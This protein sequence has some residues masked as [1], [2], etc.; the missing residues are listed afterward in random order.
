MQ[1]AS[2]SLD[3]AFDATARASDRREAAQLCESLHSHAAELSAAVSDVAALVAA[4]EEGTMPILSELRR[5]PP[6]SKAVARSEAIVAMVARLTSATQG[7]VF[8]AALEA[9]GAGCVVEAASQAVSGA[10]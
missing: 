7:K 8:A 4:W 9:F 2:A 5:L 6:P 3:K 10:L 1:E